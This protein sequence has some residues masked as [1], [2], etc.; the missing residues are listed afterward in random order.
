MAILITSFVSNHLLRCPATREVR[1]LAKRLLHITFKNHI[2]L[3]VV[4]ADRPTACLAIKHQKAKFKPLHGVKAVPVYRAI[5]L[6][7]D[8]LIIKRRATVARDEFGWSGIVEGIEA[9]AMLMSS[10]YSSNLANT[11]KCCWKCWRRYSCFI[12]GPWR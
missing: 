6:A 11:R 9:E 2:T 10:Q 7:S 8:N 1:P 3:P 4:F 5:S 12:I